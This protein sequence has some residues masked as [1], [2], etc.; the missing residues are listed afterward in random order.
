MPIAKEIS[1][2][3]ARVSLAPHR[4]ETSPKYS[5]R[6]EP[7]NLIESPGMANEVGRVTPCASSSPTLPL[8]I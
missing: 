1:E 4:G 2:M 6:I 5:S 7:L 8:E 3:P